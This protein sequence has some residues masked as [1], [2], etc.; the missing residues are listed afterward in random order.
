MLTFEDHVRWLFLKKKPLG[1]QVSAKSRIENAVAG[2]RLPWP[3]RKVPAF[4]ACLHCQNLTQQPAFA[5]LRVAA[6]SAD[7]AE[8]VS[9]A[10]VAELA[11]ARGSGPRTRK[12]VGVRVPSSAPEVK[13]NLLKSIISTSCKQ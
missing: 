6:G 5:R 9:C 1:F 13:L 10:E 12:G 8:L 2:I 3:G 4:P 7:I 11:D